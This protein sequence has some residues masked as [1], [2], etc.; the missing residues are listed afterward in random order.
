[1]KNNI[2]K[3]IFVLFFF[4]LISNAKS[5]EQFNFDV[6]EVEIS[7]N[8]NKFVGNKRGKITS[9]NGIEINADKFEYNKKS[10]ILDASGNVLII[11]NVNNY[12]IFTQKIVYKK[13]D[14]FIYT[15]NKSKAVDV[16][17]GIEITAEDFEYDLIKNI[18]T[19]KKN[20]ILENKIKNYK[21][22][23]NF[24]TYLRND[25]KI[26]TI[27]DTEA[28]VNS[29]YNFKSSNVT[30]LTDKM[31][32]FSKK[33]SII[34]DNSNLYKL[35]KFNYLINSE[36]LKGE[37]V[38]VNTKYK[39]PKNDKFYFTSA[40]VN[41]KEQ[42]FFGTDPK[43]KIHKDIFDN[44]E[45]DPR[46]F[47]V[48]ATSDNS[49]TKINKGVFT[50]CKQN[51]KCTPWSINAKQI[52]HDKDKKEIVYKNAFLKIY[53]LPVLYFPKFFHPDPTVDRRSGF[54]QPQINNSNTLGSSFSIPYFSVLAENKD[55]TFIPYIFEKNL[56]MLQN[57]YRQITEKS[58][59]YANFGFVN[60]F[61]STLDS[62]NNSIFNLFAKYELDLN[63]KNFNSSNLLLSV[64]KTTNDTFLKIFDAHFQ[65]NILKPTDYD[66]LK[67]EIKLFLNNDDYSLETGVKSFENLQK[68]N[69]DRYEYILPYYN[70]NTTLNDNFFN[71]SVVFYSNGDNILSNTNQIKSNITNDLIYNSDDYLLFN[72]LKNN[73]G[74][75]VKNLN[76]LG[77]NNSNYKSSPQIEIMSDVS[78][79]SSYPLSKI[80]T[81]EINYL[82][83][84]ILFKINPGDMKNYLNSDRIINVDNI[85]NNNR[86]GI[87][88]SLEAGK[89]ITLGFDYRKEN[90]QD[91]EKFFEIKLASVLRDKEENFIPKKTTLNKKNSNIFGSV[92]NNF[93]DFFNLNYK[94]ALDSN[95]NT[96]EY[97]NLSAQF[98]GNKFNTEF[99][100]LEENGSMGNS[101][102]LEN[103]TSFSFNEQNYI[104]FK[105]RRNRKLNLTEYY[106]LVYQYENDCLVAG[107]KYKKTYYED[108]DLRPSENLFFT[109]T[110]VPITNYEQKIE[111]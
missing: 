111:R 61:K 60:N 78:L 42:S 106:D 21:I 76:S 74:V 109:I 34:T 108:R 62:K 81:N 70:F 107:I 46:I 100:F 22:F 55:F 84:K 58:K 67:S 44:S 97:S 80:T 86:L 102:F 30:F 59:I 104:T 94:F 105:T 71:G 91:F 1:M 43:I 20:V 4:A 38:L 35:E 27:G 92:T 25:K 83:P 88:D 99:N 85:F 3:I 72:G 87:N 63:L 17:D 93:S 50:S 54:L 82:T 9:E 16:L 18:I 79:S 56:Q 52:I 73:F 77:K 36:L 45:N 53:D 2:F 13:N 8:G 69:N 10:N 23:S 14:G 29:K 26:Y 7:D 95:L 64:E 19:A 40:V 49:Y 32:L 24:I 75:N 11:D 68:N 39:L 6:T 90:L 51:E 41:L 110:L 37:K 98:I 89:S 66:N 12:K 48:S 101:N 33:K 31:E 96:I 57:E 5:N 47:G 103:S 15:K 65:D 28:L